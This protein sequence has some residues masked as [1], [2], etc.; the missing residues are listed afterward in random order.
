MSAFLVEKRNK[1]EIFH[2]DKYYIGFAFNDKTSR[3]KNPFGILIF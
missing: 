1:N 3:E 2:A